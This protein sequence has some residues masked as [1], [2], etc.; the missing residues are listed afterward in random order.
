MRKEIILYIKIRK[1]HKPSVEKTNEKQENR[2]LAFLK[3]L[4][5]FFRNITEAA[6]DEKFDD[7]ITKEV[8][9]STFYITTLSDLDDTAILKENIMKIA[10]RTEADKVW[11]E[12]YKEERFDALIS[13]YPMNFLKGIYR[14]YRKID[15]VLMISGQNDNALR[16]AWEIYGD[17]N[18]LFIVT[19]REHEWEEL[20]DIAYADS[21]LIVS[22]ISAS[23]EGKAKAYELPP[24]F[25]GGRGAL[26]VFD[27][28]KTMPYVAGRKLP[29]LL[30]DGAIYNDMAY[31]SKKSAVFQGTSSKLKYM[32]IAD[33]IAKT[34]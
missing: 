12:P 27:F 21:G 33:Y 9:G 17:L 4:S 7:Y 14:G 13:E 18:R 19:D 22:T 10:R 6:E 29:G 3:R 16:L 32:T 34:P 11:I 20:S 1:H 5:D 8:F 15:S 23:Y 31:S 2:P 25:S 28:S 26:L 24:S 30:P